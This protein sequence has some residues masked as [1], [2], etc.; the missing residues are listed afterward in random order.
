MDEI[1]RLTPTFAGVSYQSSTGMV[2]VQASR[3]NGP[4]KR[5]EKYEARSRETR[6]IAAIIPGVEAAE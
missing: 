6:R 1:A 5:Q 2:S 3:S 4:L